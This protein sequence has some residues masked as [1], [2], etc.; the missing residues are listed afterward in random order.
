MCN[1]NDIPVPDEDED[2][3]DFGACELCGGPLGL[4]GSLGFM[5]HLTC[6]N[7]GMFFTRDNRPNEEDDDDADVG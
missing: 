1:P 5:L 2:E 4:L 3:M 7:C 6:R